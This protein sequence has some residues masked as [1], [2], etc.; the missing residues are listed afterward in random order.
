MI[1]NAIIGDPDRFFTAGWDAKVIMWDLG[2]LTKIAEQPL[3]GYANTMALDGADT[4]YVGG[5]NGVIQAFHINKHT[6]GA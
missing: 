5:A 2:R 4:L 1:I 6:N 3:D